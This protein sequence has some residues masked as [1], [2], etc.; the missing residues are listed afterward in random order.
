MLE[1]EHRVD[2]C[3]VDLRFDEVAELKVVL[4]RCLCNMYLRITQ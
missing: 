2:H 4:Q 1:N 3:S